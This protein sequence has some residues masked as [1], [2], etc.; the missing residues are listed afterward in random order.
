[1]RAV[2][3]TVVYGTVSVT[4]SANGSA[5]IVMFTAFG[6][7]PSNSTIKIVVTKGGILDKGGNSLS[8]DN[9]ISFTTGTATTT[10]A[11]VLDFESGTTG[12]AFSGC[13]SIVT[14]PKWVFQS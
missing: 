8:A 11:S 5:A 2:T 4:K 3:T 1:M 10:T 12:I 6:N 14:M 9:T 7:F 13:G